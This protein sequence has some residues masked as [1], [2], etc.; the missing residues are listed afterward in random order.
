MAAEGPPAVRRSAAGSR[1]TRLWAPSPGKT[2]GQRSGRGAR[3]GHHISPA[4]RA[5]WSATNA[6]HPRA[7]LT[8]APGYT[9]LLRGASHDG[10][11]TPNSGRFRPNVRV[12]LDF[13]CTNPSYGRG[14]VR[15]SKPGYD[16]DRTKRGDIIRSRRG[17]GR[18]FCIPRNRSSRCRREGYQ[19]RPFVVT[20][21]CM[22]RRT[23]HRVVEQNTR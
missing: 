17:Y 21:L 1:R 12:C 18:V 10:E 9:R 19:N 4:S 13:V 14:S 16:P 2:E 23:R 20:Y 11:Y 3:S 7:V 22:H 15:V 5:A 6:R 8:S